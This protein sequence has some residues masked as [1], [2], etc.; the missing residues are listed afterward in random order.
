MKKVYCVFVLCAGVS[1][2]MSCGNK[3]NSQPE[4][5]DTFLAFD[6]S[7]NHGVIEMDKLHITDS[8]QMKNHTY[9]YDI[10]RVPDSTL[11]K[12]KE[13]ESQTMYSDNHVELK[14]LKDG[15]AFFQKTFTKNTFGQYLDEGFKANGV[16][17]GFVFDDVTDGGLRFATSV[18][19]PQSD[20]YIPLTV[21]IAADGT[22]TVSRETV[23]EEPAEEE[24]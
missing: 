5:Q 13:Q 2:L 11:A 12:V 16:L 17:E 22:M 8:V 20:M 4:Q 18:S 10:L 1:L 3:S 7:I 23:L 6:E 21:I 15:A 9:I 19:Y 24:D 14:I